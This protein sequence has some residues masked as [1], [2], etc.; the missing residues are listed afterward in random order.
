M[1]DTARK[2]GPVAL[3]LGVVLMLWYA[4]AVGMN[5][6]GVIERVLA[7]RP[8]WTTGEL[9]TETLRME[10]PLLPAPHQVALD[11]YSSIVD[12]PLDS[13]RNLLFH[14]A[15]TGALAVMFYRQTAL[16]IALACAYAFAY[17]LCYRAL[18]RVPEGQDSSADPQAGMA[19]ARRGDWGGPD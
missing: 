19:F 15:V 18:A 12:W 4:G 16:L 1:T 8:G 3:V 14:V 13:P 11:L 9:V 7:D 17:H 10:R 5:A 2:A 6:Q